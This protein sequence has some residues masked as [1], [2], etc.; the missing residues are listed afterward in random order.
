MGSVMN[1]KL[2]NLRAVIEQYA[3]SCEQEERDQA[4]MVRFLDQNDDCLKR[5]NQTAHFTASAWIV[6]PARDKVLM[7]Y[8]NIYDSWSWTGG[9]ADGEPDLMSVA[10]RE[11]REETGVKELKILRREPVSLEIITVDG[12]EKRG[13]YV[14][15]HL[16]L[17]LTYLLEAEE[18]QRLTVKEDENSGVQW[19]PVRDLG[20]Y[21]SEPWMLER[22]YSKLSDQ[23]S[24]KLFQ[25]FS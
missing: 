6:N 17:N 20:D 23:L 9:H 22:I 19:I 7:V 15:S 18:S 24:S 13:A 4:V 12:H 1:P 14:P 21:V 5:S 25:K 11:A 8:H 10:V 16:H 3:P 2:K